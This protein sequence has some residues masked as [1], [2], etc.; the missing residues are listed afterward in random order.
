MAQP[1]SL[2]PVHYSIVV[3]TWPN[4][5]PVL[6]VNTIFVVELKEFPGPTDNFGNSMTRPLD[7]DADTNTDAPPADFVPKYYTITVNL[8]SKLSLSNQLMDCEVETISLSLLFSN[9][10]YSYRLNLSQTP[11]NNIRTKFTHL[12]ANFLEHNITRQDRE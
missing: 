4:V 5:I 8:D 2:N 10:L 7:H 12:I 3:P 11:S 9:I 1:S 6:L